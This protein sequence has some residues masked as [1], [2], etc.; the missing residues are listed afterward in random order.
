M[1]R[2]QLVAVM[3]CMF[4]LY[5]SA[6]ELT[7]NPKQFDALLDET[8]SIVNEAVKSV[9]NSV[10][11]FDKTTDK[12]LL[13]VD[14]TTHAI[15]NSML[16][17]FNTTL[18]EVRHAFL[19][20]TDQVCTTAQQ[21][22][23]GI[24]TTAG[25]LNGELIATAKTLLGDTLATINHLAAEFRQIANTSIAETRA[26][27]VYNVRARAVDIGKVII[28]SAFF[29]GFIMI[30]SKLIPRMPHRAK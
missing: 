18:L 27:L 11:A 21:I 20:V 26:E 6:F 15:T 1:T 25:S 22:Q 13:S 7:I 5:A 12:V 10:L 16:G 23:K 29:F 17:T 19:N 4:V 28:G 24:A 3:L 14:G 30:I 2:K 8:K 9:D